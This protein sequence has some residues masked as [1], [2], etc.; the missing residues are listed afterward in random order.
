[1][2]GWMERRYL[3]LPKGGLILAIVIGLIIL[4]GGLNGLL[5]YY[6]SAPSFWWASVLVI[7][8]VILL[9]NA[10]YRMQKRR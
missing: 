3:G 7:F 9:A 1:M 6:Y 4:I 5:S 8:G 2:V 10:F